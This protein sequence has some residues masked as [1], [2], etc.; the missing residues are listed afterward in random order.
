[1][2]IYFTRKSF[3]RKSGHYQN[4]WIFTI[5]Q[6]VEKANLNCTKQ[7]QELDNVY[8][9]DKKNYSKNLVDK[10]KNTKTTD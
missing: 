5:R 8:E 6:F 3:V 4:I 9:F 1:M 2:Q 10:S 7:D